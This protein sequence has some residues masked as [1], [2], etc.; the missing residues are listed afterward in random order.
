[1]PRWLTRTCTRV[2]RLVAAGEILFTHKASAEIKALDLF[3]SRVDAAAVLG[4]LSPK[5]FRQRVQSHER[6]EWLYVFAP[7]VGDRLL[8][9]KLALRSRCVVVSFHDEKDEECG[10]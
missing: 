2:H 1:M 8:Y 3:L 5:D 6:G 9:I 10:A 7:K 4:T